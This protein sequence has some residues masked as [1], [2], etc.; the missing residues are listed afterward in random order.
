MRSREAFYV[1]AIGCFLSVALVIPSV[2]YSARY[3]GGNPSFHVIF[4]LILLAAVVS[5]FV[6]VYFFTRKGGRALAA[7][8]LG[9][10][11]SLG[12]AW[13]IYASY[14]FKPQEFGYV[15]LVFAPFLEAAIGVPISLVIIFIVNRLRRSEKLR[16]AGD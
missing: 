3:G 1:L 12:H 7:L 16:Q 14:A 6:G 8:T 11:F 9:V 13:M 5:P 4:N 2:L 15:G 10:V